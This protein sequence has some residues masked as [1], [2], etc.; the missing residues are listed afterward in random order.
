METYLPSLV[1]ADCLWEIDTP[2][3]ISLFFYMSLN[4]DNKRDLKF[5]LD[6]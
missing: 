1:M 2:K 4:I 5:Y 3:F 6:I